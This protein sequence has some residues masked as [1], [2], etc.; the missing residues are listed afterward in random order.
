L[1]E[2][3]EAAARVASSKL[4]QI[5]NDRPLS[6]LTTLGVGGTARYYARA[7][8]ESDVFEAVRFAEREGVPLRVLGG[9][10]NVVVSDEAFPGLVLHM[11]TRGF[12]LEDDG[13]VVALVAAA[14]EPW[15]E[16]VARSVAEN[17]QGLECL[18]GIPGRVGAT[19]LQNVGA[20]GQ[21]VS[22]TIERVRALDRRT[23]AVREFSNAECHFEYRQSLFKTTEVD[24]YVVLS[25]RF[26]LRRGAAP[27]VAYAELAQRLTS[28]AAPS[29]SEVRDTVLGLRRAKSMLA[30]PGDP[31]RRSCGSFFLNPV[32]SQPDYER[33]VARADGAKVPAYPQPDGRV[34]VA[35]AFLIER[36]G[37]PRGSRAGNVGQSTEHALALVCHDGASARDVLDYAARIRAGVRQKF[38]VEL[39]PEPVFWSNAT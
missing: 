14:G 33:V 1:A 13:D 25:V 27:K 5:T 19:P 10:S 26:L 20:Y 32:L 7:E 11:N 23:G 17:L 29:L 3:C 38:G 8:R 15:D 18:S 4:V 37:F 31:N 30:E 16:T 22:E 28:R 34:K 6:E 12:A 39:V 21:D 36:A 35:A 9:G 2:T 24:R